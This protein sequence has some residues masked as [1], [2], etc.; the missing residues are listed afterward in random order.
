MRPIHGGTV[1]VQECS[2]AGRASVSKT[3]GRGFEPLHSC[4]AGSA[5]AVAQPMLDTPDGR[6]TAACR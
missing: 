5:R 4:Q 6:P 3:E 1:G 2:S